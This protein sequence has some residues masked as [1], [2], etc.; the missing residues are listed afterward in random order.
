MD[1]TWLGSCSLAQ[2][3]VAQALLPVLLRVSFFAALGEEQILRFA[4]D[5][6]SF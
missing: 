6:M 1:P 3:G 4:Q 5:G 2:S